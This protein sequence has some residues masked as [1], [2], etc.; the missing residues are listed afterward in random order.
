MRLQ[1][2]GDDLIEAGIPEGPEI[3]RRLAATLERKLDRGL[4]DDREAEL[5]FAVES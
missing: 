5:R 3:G 2:T 4:P 1:I